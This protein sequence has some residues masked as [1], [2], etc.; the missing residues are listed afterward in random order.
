MLPYALIRPLLFTL[1]AERAHE[2]TLH[3]LSLASSMGLVRAGRQ[4]GSPV[5]VMGLQF[6]NRVGLAAGLD[7]NGVAIDG[8]AGL[9]F[10]FIEVGTVTP[11]PQPGNPKPRLFRL[12]EQQAIINRMGFN[13]EGIDALL[14]R[15]PGI[16]FRGI[17]GINIG[18][19]F[20]TPIEKAADDYLI[21]LEK[22]YP[23]A[24]Y[25]AINISSPNTKN[26]RQLQG[27]S[28]LDALLGALKERQAELAQR[29][30]KYVPLALKIAPDLDA[31]QI[32]NIADALRRHRLDAVIATNTTLG[33]EGVESS[34]LAMEA[35][36]LSGSPLFEK[37]TQVIR[38]LARAIDGELPIIAAGGI[39]DGKRASAKIEAGATL[40][41]LYSGLIYRGP[42]LV[43]ECIAATNDP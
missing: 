8:L 4:S 7:K 2:I 13:N 16:G 42:A 10:G 36:G 30:G 35:G 22:A 39:T 29:H 20:D 18:K 14:Q 27:N 3:S 23:A 38:L 34:P 19:N 24:S 32:T 1:D 41:Q 26:L 40:V 12:P 11:R 6:P 21:C 17:L 31:D 25:I 43:A 9:G 33:R 5:T 15:L 37:S 28:E